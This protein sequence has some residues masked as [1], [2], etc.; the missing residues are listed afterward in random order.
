MQSS[1]FQSRHA[2]RLRRREPYSR[3]FHPFIIVEWL[4][5]ATCIQPKLNS[6]LTSVHRHGHWYIKQLSN[7]LV[8][9]VGAESHTFIVLAGG[10]DLAKHIFHTDRVAIRVDVD[11]GP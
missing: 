2:K 5:I 1:V 3:I 8:H 11:I 6:I 10:I 7:E 9:K 4:Y